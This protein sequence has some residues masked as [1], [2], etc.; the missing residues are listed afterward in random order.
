MTRHSG[1]GRFRRLR[2]RTLTWH[3]RHPVAGISLAA[4][5]D[6]GDVE[7]DP[8]SLDYAAVIE[9]LTEP[10]FP[11]LLSLPAPRRTAAFDAYLTEIAGYVG[12]LERLFVI[13]RQAVWT[14]RLRSRARLRTRDKLDLTDPALAAVALG[15]DTTRLRRDP[16]T[17]GLLF[18]SA[19]FHDLSVLATPIG[20]EVRH[21]RDSN[22]RELDAV[23]TLSDGR[24]AAV[25]V[26][27]GGVQI[28]PAARSIAAAVA[29]IDTGAVGEPMF[30][31]IVT[32]T[33]STFGLDDGTITVPLHRLIP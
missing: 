27:L 24:W 26:K 18:E 22:G 16:E 23:L 5:I 29:D 11:G 33:G 8:D 14:P 17:A 31:L 13:D 15:A 7:P 1:A 28:P 30:R 20:G 25:E 12:L 6:G 10:G 19:A 4:L 3:E 9:R 32:G 21:Y 2:Q